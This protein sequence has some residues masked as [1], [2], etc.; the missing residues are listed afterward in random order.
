MYGIKYSL[1]WELHCPLVKSSDD[2]KC[3]WKV[4]FTTD[5]QCFSPLVPLATTHTVSLWPQPGKHWCLIFCYFKGYFS[6]VTRASFKNALS[7]INI[8]HCFSISRLMFKSKC[9][10]MESYPCYQDEDT[11]VAFADYT[12]NYPD[13]PPNSWFIVFR[14]V[15]QDSIFR[16]R[17]VFR[18]AVSGVT[19]KVPASRLL[20]YLFKTFPYIYTI[21]FSICDGMSEKF[22]NCPYI[23]IGKCKQFRDLFQ[24]IR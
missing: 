4:L 14:Q 15:V 7:L 12:V 13:Q 2:F 3:I 9:K 19:V 16:W 5:P 24:W 8:C 10:S 20:S 21:F 22:I 1:A 23:K 6:F 18:P 11:K 17:A